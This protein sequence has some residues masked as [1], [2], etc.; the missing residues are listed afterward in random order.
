M[1][2]TLTLM[3]TLTLTMFFNWFNHWIYP[4]FLELDLYIGVNFTFMMILYWFGLWLLILLWILS[5]K[6]LFILTFLQLHLDLFYHD[7]FLWPIPWTQFYN[8]FPTWL[9]NY[10][11][12]DLD[13][14]LDLRIDISLTFILI[15]NL[16]CPCILT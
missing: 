3:L 14:Y 11:Y 2:L 6:C 4:H 5:F 13:L 7:F 10:P 9:E 15:S 8:W 12:L 16:I 1:H